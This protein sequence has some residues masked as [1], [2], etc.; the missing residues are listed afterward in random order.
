M[1][2]VWRRLPMRQ[3]YKKMFQTTCFLSLTFRGCHK[4]YTFGKKTYEILWITIWKKILSNLT[5]NNLEKNL[6]KSYE[7]TIWKKIL[8]ILMNNNLEK[9]LMKSYEWTIW[10][11]SYEFLWITIWKKSYEILRITIWKKHLMK[12]YEKQFGKSYEIL[13]I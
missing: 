5:N 10:K 4:F 8:W 12:S 9:N 13:W 6:M 3:K 2:K 7:W 11:K 1:L